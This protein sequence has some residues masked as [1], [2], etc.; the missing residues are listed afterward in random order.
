MRGD[1]TAEVWLEVSGVHLEGVVWDGTA[2]RLRFVDIPRGRVFDADPGTAEAGWFIL[3]APV[4]AVHP[5]TDPATLLIADGEGM[6]LTS[7]GVLTERLAS[8]LAG[9]PEIR[10][11]DGNVDPAGRYLAGSMAYAITP[12]AGALYRLDTDRSLHTLLTGVTIGNGLDWSPDG[13]F[14][15]FVDSTTRRVDVFDYDVPSGALTGR[16]TFADT[17]E[18][19][20]IPDGLTVDADGG[21][22]VAFWGGSRVVRYDPG[23]RLDLTILLPVTQVTSCAFGGPGLD[24]LFITTSTEELT[25]GQL[26]DQPAAGAVFRA[27]PGR[28][29]RPSNR[30]VI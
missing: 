15:Y 5:T 26:R 21:V 4:T 29:G 18:L 27:E 24:Q 19:P 3:P 28:R 30:F 10:M 22:W 7:G 25:P 2:G 9:R 1:L 6:A 23:G 16:R 20:G 8:P 11:N 17:S 13:T 12:G 14:C